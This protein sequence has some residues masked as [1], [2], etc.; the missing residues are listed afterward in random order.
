MRLPAPSSVQPLSGHN[1]SMIVYAASGENTVVSA[2]VPADFR[3]ARASSPPARS[4]RDR[5]PSAKLLAT[6]K[7][8]AG[9][10]GLRKPGRCGRMG[11]TAAP[12][13]RRRPAKSEQDTVRTA[14]R[15]KAERMHEN[16]RCA[17]RRSPLLPGA[18]PI[19]RGSRPRTARLWK[20]RPPRIGRNP[21]PR[22][23]RFPPRS[24]LTALG[25]SG[26]GNRRAQ[27][28]NCRGRHRPILHA[29]RRRPASPR[30]TAALG[31][32]R[33][34]PAADA[35]GTPIGGVITADGQTA[36]ATFPDA[37]RPLLEN[38]TAF[39]CPKVSDSPAAPAGPRPF[40]K[41]QPGGPP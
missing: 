35:A 23:R 28:G 21:H 39:R 41:K 26:L 18:T 4:G 29:A 33:L 16:P 19:R 13:G 38:G 1:F 40:P 9:A 25:T 6:C 30:R 12:P 17:C 27:P 2:T 32:W 7:G 20:R 10:T 34:F 24:P 37:T 36:T 15:G 11:E 22:R 31:K 3:P 14:P 5:V 8:A